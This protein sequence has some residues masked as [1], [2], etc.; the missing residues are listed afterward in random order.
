MSQL[1]GLLA[2]YIAE[3][4]ADPFNHY[5]YAMELYKSAPQDA[6]GILGQLVTEHPE[7]LATYYTLGSWL[8]DDEQ[9]EQ[10][11]AILK[12]GIDLAEQQGNA[13]TLS[14]L[15]RAL[16]NAEAEL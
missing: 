8:V 1:L 11:I 5:A 6:I 4:P 10:A 3:D 13:K 9:F 14:E 2:Q 16:L 12:Q 7:Y 15:K